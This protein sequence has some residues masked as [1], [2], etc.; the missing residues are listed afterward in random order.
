MPAYV[1]VNVD[2]RD[3]DGY[4]DYKGPAAATVAE[5][6]GRYLVRGGKAERR[7]GEWEPKR[8]VILEFPSFEAAQA[9]YD[10]DSYAA[11]RDTRHR[12]AHADLVIVEGV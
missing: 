6:G 10:S 9:W 2:V 12:T 5:H 3:P 4:E 11:V 1:I 8:V 7:E